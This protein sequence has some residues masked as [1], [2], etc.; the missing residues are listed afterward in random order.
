[1]PSSAIS[2]MRL[3]AD[4]EQFLGRHALIEGVFLNLG[5]GMDQMA[6][7]RLLPDDLGVVLGIAQGR[8]GFPQIDQV[9]MAADVGDQFLFVEIVGQG[10]G[11]GRL[12]LMDAESVMASKIF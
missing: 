2:R 5:A 10:D 7:D 4:A 6:D 12:A 11:I 8:G 3:S 1:M 9:G